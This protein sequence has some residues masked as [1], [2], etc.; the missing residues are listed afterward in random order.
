MPAQRRPG[1]AAQLA[2]QLDA[3]NRERRELE[4]GMREQ[5]EAGRWSG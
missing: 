3:I 1:A 2:A 5:A 4:A